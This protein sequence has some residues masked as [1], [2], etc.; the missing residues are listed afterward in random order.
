LRSR[1]V[2]VAIV[3]LD[4]CRN[5]P[6]RRVGTRAIGNERGFVLA[7]QVEGTFSLCSA[8]LGEAALD[9]LSGQSDPVP[10]PMLPESCSG[11]RCGQKRRRRKAKRSR[12]GLTTH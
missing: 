6:F 10:R 7:K 9:R 11:E 3:V 1:G 5:N 8:G 12:R 4:V 2:R